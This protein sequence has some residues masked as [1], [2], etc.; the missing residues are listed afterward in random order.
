MDKTSVNHL[1]HDYTDVFILSRLSRVC[2][3]CVQLSD[4]TTHDR[5]RL[6]C[7]ELQ[8]FPP[9]R[10]HHMPTSRGRPLHLTLW[11]YR[12]YHDTEQYSE[13]H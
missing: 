4:T 5:R 3:D 7:H 8:S 12:Q 2:N 13:Y 11:L 1:I 10:L 6:S 9:L